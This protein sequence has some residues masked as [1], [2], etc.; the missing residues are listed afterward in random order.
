MGCLTMNNKL[1][2]GIDLRKATRALAAITFSLVALPMFAQVNTGRISGGITDQT[3]GAIS[4]A[5]VTVVDVARGENRDL[6]SDSAGQYAAPN[7]LPGVYTVRAE[8][9]GFETINRENVQVTAGGDIHVDITLQPGATTQTVT[10]TEALPMVNTTNAQTGGT[11]DN[12]ALSQLPINGRNYRWQANYVPGVM[13]GVGEGSSNQTVN[14]TPVS[15]GMWNMIFDGLISSTYFTLETNAGGTGEGGDSTLMP[16]DAIQEM[17]VVLNPKAEYGWAPGV[18]EN[19]ALKSGTNLMHGSAYAYGRDTALDAKNAVLGVTAPVNFE[20]FGASLGGP[21]KKDKI[22]YFAAYEGEKIS[23]AS[24]FS[25][26]APTL[27]SGSGTTNSIPDAIAAM[28]AGGQPFSALSLNLA[29]CNTANAAIHGLTGAA[30]APAC[31][32]TNALGAPGLFGNY[33]AGTTSGVVNTS[34]NFPEYG[35]SNNGLFKVDY[36]INDHHSMSGSFY[37]GRYHEYV[38]PNGSQNFTQP[39]WEELL[40]VESVMGRIVEIWTPNSNWL[41]Q[42]RVGVDHANRPVTR[43]EC[44][45]GDT[46]NPSGAGAS[47]GGSVGGVAGPNYLNSY[48]LNTQFAAGCGIPT[49]SINGFTGKLGFANNRI[50][51]EDPISGADSVSYTRGTHQFKF[52]ADVRAENFYGAKVLDSISGVIA[53]GT[54]NFNAFTNATA[55]Q[56]FLAGQPATEQIRAAQANSSVSENANIRH[57]TAYKMAFFAQDDWRIKPRLTLNLGFRYEVETPERDALGLL[58]QFVPGTPT[59][60]VQQNIILPYQRK[61]EPRLGFAYDLTGKGTTVVRAGGGLMYMIPQLMNYVAGGAGIDYGGEPTGATLYNA[62]GTIASKP[63]GTITSSLIAPTA[64]TNSSNNI[65]AGGN[66]PW[67]AGQAIFPFLNPATFTAQCG[68]GLAQNPALAPTPAGGANPVNPSTCTGQGGNPNLKLFPYAFWNLNVQHA[69]TNKVSVDIGYVGSRTWNLIATANLNQPVPG[70][71]GSS[72][73]TAGSEYFRTPYNFAANNATGSVYPWFGTINYLVNGGG[74]NYAGLQMNVTARNLHGFTLNGNYTFSHALVQLFEQATGTLDHGNNTLD[75]R[76]HL[77]LQAS[78]AI[79]GIKA[80]GQMLEGWAVNGTINMLSGLPL[81]L[82]DSR[83]DLF[84]CGSSCADRW[85]LYGSAKDFNSI[86]G[87]AGT[88]TCYGLVGSK[89]VPTS[90]PTS[91]GC[92]PVAGGTGSAGAQTF[93]SNFPIACQQGAVAAGT[94]TAPGVTSATSPKNYNGLAQLATIGCYTA[95]GSAMVPPAQGMAGTMFGS[96]LRG[97]GYGLL[98]LSLTKTWTIKERLKTQFRW[99]IFNVLNRTQYAAPGVNLGTPSALGLATTT[100]DVTHG[101][102]VVG[103]GGPREMQLALRFDF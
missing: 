17:Q 75:T 99:E 46:S 74:S 78:Y 90:N 8:F 88:V 87:G 4:G 81:A 3:G 11:L 72:P 47:T 93:V 23:T 55:L 9:M 28:N 73:T 12:Q 48:G 40:G 18:T 38:V 31:T 65:I 102:A 24:S 52:G 79:P 33:N 63:T 1:R 36:H 42:A 43:G 14:G 25:L 53:F 60:M 30:V 2:W 83:D 32:G 57:I 6:V 95:G 26:Q 70:I 19:I 27:T 7:L 37:M 64:I 96:E 45:N 50:D 98:N 62:N 41:N 44:T 67:T 69:F 21:I 15:N 92:I 80:P 82:T 59:G 97:K 61:P 103:S 101:N 13:T 71:S 56:D 89:F 35:G 84:G 51:W 100:P 76:H 20:Q 49:I 94:S 39:Y 86:L 29:G 58:G 77:S 10:V 16:L 66:L 34:E 85:N 5:K 22:F 91:N 68:N 54:T